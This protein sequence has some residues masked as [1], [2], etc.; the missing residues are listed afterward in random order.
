[1]RIKNKRYI[2]RPPKAGDLGWIV[3]R[4]GILY[5]Q[6]FGW[7]ERFEG[8]VA[9]IVGEFVEKFD[10][11]YERCWVAE[12]DKGERAGSVFVVKDQEGVAKLRLL[13]VEPK[14]RGLGIGA[15]LVEQ[16]V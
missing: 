6:E 10:P 15:D 14:A 12:L 5:S 11:A 4:H 13:L 9:K 16:C 8:L 7:N 2:L 3:Y 1:M